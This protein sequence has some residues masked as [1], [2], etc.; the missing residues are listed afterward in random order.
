VK[1]LLKRDL[2]SVIEFPRLELIILP[3]LLIFVVLSQVVAW[4]W[5]GTDSIADRP[6]I[7]IQAIIDSCKL[8]FTYPILIIFIPMIIVDSITNE[9]ERG[10]MLMLVSYPVQR[11][12]I[13]VS[14]L[15]SI[16]S[17]S[18]VV[19]FFTSLAGTLVVY[20][21]HA[22][23]PSLMLVLAL[24]VS[25]GI[26]CFFVCS[27]STLISTIANRTVTAAMASLTIVLSWPLIVNVFSWQLKLPN[28]MA[29]SY[30]GSVPELIDLLTLKL[31][32]SEIPATALASV[33]AQV[34]LASSFLFLSYIV[35]NKKEFK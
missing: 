9:Y 20:K 19:I 33:I 5:M 26:L 1:L 4:G 10:T 7:L 8:I 2:K 22:M 30:T 14:K 23:L 18:W 21:N 34:L 13:L 12:E 29:L 25:T 17:V 11:S 16:F 32:R 27:V 28:L 6:Q 35:L 24:L 15:A 3:T 31:G